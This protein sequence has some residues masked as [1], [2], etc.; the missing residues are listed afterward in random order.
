MSFLSA[1]TGDTAKNLQ[2][3]AGVLVENLQ[4]ID[5]FNGE[6]TGSARL[7]G[8]TEGGGSFTATPELR[9]IFEG[10]DGAR[11]NYKDGN[12]VDNW[13][14]T[15]TATLKEMTA[16]NL[17][18]ALGV[19]DIEKAQSNGKYDKLKPR[20]EVK[21]EDYIGNI[22]WLGKMNNSDTPMIIEIKN[23]MNTNGISFTATDKGT[24]TVEVELK[25]HFDLKKPNEV[26]FAIYF[27]KAT[28][29]ETQA[30]AELEEE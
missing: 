29:A 17:K 6:L 25:A 23:V 1:F 4:N 21:S 18:L 8:A 28:G 2:L 19:G 11:G 26:P 27:P 16:K 22:C 12:V 10:I 15:F 24:G 30:I 20:M 13:D 9:N 3:D 7:L 14:I 5:Q